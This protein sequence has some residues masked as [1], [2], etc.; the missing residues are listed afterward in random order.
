MNEGNFI[1]KRNKESWVESETEEIE[2]EGE[3][4][5]KSEIKNTSS[6]RTLSR[7][8]DHL[9]F[10]H[11]LD[12]HPTLQDGTTSLFDVSFLPIER[13]NASSTCV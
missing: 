5:I 4:I 13:L 2:K 12:P 6:C 1:R 10:N 11:L 8:F 7:L 9:L 3:C